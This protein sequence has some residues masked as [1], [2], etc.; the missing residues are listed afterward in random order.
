MAKAEPDTINEDWDQA[1]RT[2]SRL[3]RVVRYVLLVL[4]LIVLAG[5]FGPLLVAQ[6]RHL[7]EQ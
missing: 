6:C 2:T 5:K 3:L 7:G 1:A 4:A